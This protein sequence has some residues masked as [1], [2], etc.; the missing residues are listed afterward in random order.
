MSSVVVPHLSLRLVF[1]YVGF[2]ILVIPNFFVNPPS[3]S[4]EDVSIVTSKTFGSVLEGIY[5]D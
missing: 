4:E 2:N 1:C 3:S 5:A